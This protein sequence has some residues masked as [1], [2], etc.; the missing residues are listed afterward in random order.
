MGF[1]AYY[2]KACKYTTWQDNT[3]RKIKGNKQKETSNMKP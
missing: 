3:K 1:N 2:Q